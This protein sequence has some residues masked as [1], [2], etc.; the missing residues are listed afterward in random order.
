M[1]ILG[2]SVSSALAQT[3]DLI[4]LDTQN[5]YGQ[6]SIDNVHVVEKQYYKIIYIDVHVKVKDLALEDS[7]TA[8]LDGIT[9]TNENGKKYQSTCTNVG[10]GTFYDTQTVSGRDGGIGMRSLCYMVEK[11]FS[12]F[13]VYYTIPYYN[14]NTH[15]TQIGD[16]VLDQRNDP[17]INPTS[18]IGN[19]NTPN[20][21]DFFS[22][23]IQW[24][25]N[26]FKFS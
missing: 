3:S 26:L 20:T 12:N 21:L 18:D 13:K 15:S 17:T 14:F 24:F 7:A 11:E 9:L 2:S 16:I 1:I 6:F 5:H 19:S 8:Y 22:Q 10:A 4:L 25:K 23:L